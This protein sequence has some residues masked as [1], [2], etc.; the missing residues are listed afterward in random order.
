MKVRYTKNHNSGKIGE[1]KEQSE[2]FG[3]YLILKGVAV[4]ELK[5]KRITKELKLPIQTK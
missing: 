2:D 5:E 3:N 4:K 1:V